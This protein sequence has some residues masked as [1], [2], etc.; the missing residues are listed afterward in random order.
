MKIDGKKEEEIVVHWLENHGYYKVVQDNNMIVADGK[1]RKMVIAL[2][3][4][5]IEI[6][7]EEA[8]KRH[9]EAWLAVVESEDDDDISWTA[10][11]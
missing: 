5:H 7:K 3:Q 10:I 8:S 11:K 4:K 1:M 2:E 9:R 6:A